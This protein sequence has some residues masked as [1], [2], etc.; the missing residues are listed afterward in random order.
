LG[1][2]G[3]VITFAKMMFEKSPTLSSK[4]LVCAILAMAITVFSE[5]IAFEAFAKR[6]L[7]LKGVGAWI[8]RRWPPIRVVVDGC[9]CVASLNMF[10]M[11]C[12]FTLMTIWAML[13]AATH[14]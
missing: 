6:P 7:P 13:S 8:Q 5:E 11:A 3:V 1:V 10:A 4:V 14:L 9:G 12:L 2:L